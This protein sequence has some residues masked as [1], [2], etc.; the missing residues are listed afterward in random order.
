M[1]DSDMGLNVTQP[2]VPNHTQPHRS[3]RPSAAAGGGDPLS[4]PLPS[5]PDKNSTGNQEQRRRPAAEKEKASQGKDADSRDARCLKFSFRVE[6][7]VPRHGGRRRR[8]QQ[9][10]T[11][12]IGDK[13]R[14]PIPLISST[15]ASDCF[16]VWER[17]GEAR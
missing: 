16:C 6:F 11:A 12:F 7:L 8:Q 5:V 2:K 9:K 14:D 10:A 13:T 15:S 4:L 3:S 17:R 1:D